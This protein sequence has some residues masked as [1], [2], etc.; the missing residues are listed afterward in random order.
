MRRFPVTLFLLAALGLVV[1]SCGGD[2]DG[3]AQPTPTE[4]DLTGVTLEAAAVWVQPEQGRFEMV[5]DAF[6]QRTG[7]T[8]NF[9]STGDDIAA[10][11]RPRIEQGSPPDVAILPQPALLR[12]FA[13]E[14][15]L[16]AIDDFISDEL[17]ANYSEDAAA[18]GVADGTTYGIWF[19]AANKSTVWYNT[20][21]FEDA[22]VTP[23]AD[24]DGLVQAAE[25]IRDSGVTPLSV[26]GADGWTLT[27]WFENVYL[28]VAGSDTYDQLTAHEIPW[29]DATV[30]TALETLAELWKP[31]LISGNPLQI[32]FN[33]SVTRTF[34]DAPQ[35]AL[36][37]EGDFVAGVISGD[38]NAVVGEDADFFPF[39]SIDGASPSVVGGGDMAVLMRDTPG[40]RAL[41]EYL[42]TPEAAEIW[43][44]EG[45]FLSPM[46]TVDLSSYPDEIT[47]RVAEGLATAEQVRF[48][49]SDLAPPAFGSTTG[50]GMWKLFQDFLRDPSDIQ[51]IQQQLE[52]AAARA[53][54]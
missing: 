34:A 40:G 30:T 51:G 28:Q 47:R 10:V 7:A 1:A 13:E 27:D 21:L 22:G 36:V 14:G 4:I 8:V 41:L 12:A 46:R 20:A 43:I 42:A 45:G 53:Y 2:G 9:T 49:M 3:G 25:T 35:A 33:N 26:G 37:Y 38:T 15:R 44:A 6:E 52:A 31:G 29:T 50:A 18:L 24:W 54:G 23:P 11:L 32:D 48:D 5:L 17:S 39:P 16:I 19:K